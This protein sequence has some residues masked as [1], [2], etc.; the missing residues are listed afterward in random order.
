MPKELSI[1]VIPRVLMC[2]VRT[3]RIS[4]NG[5][6]K[7]WVKETNPDLSYINRFTGFK[8][9]VKRPETATHENGAGGIDDVSAGRRP[10]IT[11]INGCK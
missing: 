5:D 1:N 3:L 8:Q 11:A 9:T 6:G 10:R 4:I 2:P 7:L